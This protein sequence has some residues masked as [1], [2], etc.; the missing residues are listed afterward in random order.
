MEVGEWMGQR[1]QR[2]LQDSAAL[3]SAEADD[4]PKVRGNTVIKD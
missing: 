4:R 1:M 2:L 3:V